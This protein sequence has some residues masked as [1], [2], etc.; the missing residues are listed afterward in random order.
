MAGSHYVYTEQ[1][2]KLV[3]YIIVYK[4]MNNIPLLQIYE[5]LK[6]ISPHVVGADNKLYLS[7]RTFLSP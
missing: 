7:D 6:R 3:E 1:R 2:Y 4:S 5:G